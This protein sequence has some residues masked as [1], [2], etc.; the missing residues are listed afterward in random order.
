MLKEAQLMSLGSCARW[1]LSI[2]NLALGIDQMPDIEC[3]FA[4]R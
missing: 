1:A 4:E 2:E 3:D